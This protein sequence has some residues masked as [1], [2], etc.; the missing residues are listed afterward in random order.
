MDVYF[1]TN[2]TTVGQDSTPHSFLDAYC[3]TSPTT[4]GQVHPT[5]HKRLFW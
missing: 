5:V 3:C 4:V 2:P 1:C